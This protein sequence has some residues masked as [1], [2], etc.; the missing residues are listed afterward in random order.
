MA[1]LCLG[2]RVRRVPRAD[3]GVGRSPPPVASQTSLPLPVP[4]PW[5]FTAVL[6]DVSE[7]LFSRVLWRRWLCVYFF[8]LS[9]RN[10]LRI[11]NYTVGQR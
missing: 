11:L 5:I 7:V 6:F 4:L 2:G 8:F 10:E 9:T 3:G 1:G